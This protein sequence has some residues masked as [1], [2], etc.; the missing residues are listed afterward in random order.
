MKGVTPF[1]SRFTNS[2]PGWLS[3]R[4]VS[5]RICFLL[6]GILCL[7]SVFSNFQGQSMLREHSRSLD[8]LYIRMKNN[9]HYE[10]LH[11]PQLSCRWHF[12]MSNLYKPSGHLCTV[13][14]LDSIAGLSSIMCEFVSTY[15]G[16]GVAAEARL[17]SALLLI[18]FQFEHALCTRASVPNLKNSNLRDGCCHF[19]RTWPYNCLLARHK[20]ANRLAMHWNGVYLS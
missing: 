9:I 2:N 1:N 8:V 6:T 15:Y 4:L 16:V 14:M 3:A 13:W 12:E 17:L 20:L 7:S 10:F 5:F 11:P 19:S 18:I